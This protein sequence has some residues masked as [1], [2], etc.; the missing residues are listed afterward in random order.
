MTLVFEALV[1]ISSSPVGSALS[2]RNIIFWEALRL[3]FSSSVTYFE[4]WLPPGFLVLIC[5]FSL[6]VTASLFS[7]LS[8]A[9][10]TSKACIDSVRCGIYY[11]CSREMIGEKKVI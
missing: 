5:Q 2:L 10:V 11:C 7:S 9:L 8:Q 1:G 6:V 4:R 3:N